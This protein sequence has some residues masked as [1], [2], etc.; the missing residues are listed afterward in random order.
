MCYWAQIP[1]NIFIYVKE[2]VVLSSCIHLPRYL[3][4][5]YFSLSFLGFFFFPFFNFTLCFGYIWLPERQVL[6][7][8]LFF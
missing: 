4:V 5:S 6:F 1:P 8:F 7:L 2:G 3:T